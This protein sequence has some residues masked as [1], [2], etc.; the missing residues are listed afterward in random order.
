MGWTE[1]PPG[2]PLEAEEMQKVLTFADRPAARYRWSTG[3]ILG[4]F[5]EGLRDGKILASRC[6][7]KCGRIMVPPRS[8]CELDYVRV[9]EMVPVRDTGAIETYSISYLD[10]DAR[11]IQEPILVGVVSIDGASPKMGLM[12]YFSEVTRESIHIGMKVKA[13]WRPQEERT[14]S[15]TDIR[16]FRPLRPGEG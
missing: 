4:Q 9:A 15:V 5:L 12:H 11:R 16:H 1:Q 6:P 3:K 7:G 8:F 10:T 2:H 13:E 14:G